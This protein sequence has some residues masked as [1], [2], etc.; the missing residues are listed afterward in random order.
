MK[1]EIVTLSGTPLDGLI[2]LEHRGHF[3]GRRD[4]VVHVLKMAGGGPRWNPLPSAPTRLELGPDAIGWPVYE[5]P[6]LRME[7]SLL[8]ARAREPSP[9]EMADSGTANTEAPI[10]IVEVHRKSPRT[11]RAYADA[12][13]FAWWIL[14]SVSWSVAVRGRSLGVRKSVVVLDTLKAQQAGLLSAADGSLWTPRRQ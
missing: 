10:T 7:Q 6:V 14:D 2:R 1:G 13:L 11:P 3:G 4:L 9:I 5:I 12:E 8:Q